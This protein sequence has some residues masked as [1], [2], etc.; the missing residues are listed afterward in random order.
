MFQKVFDIFWEERLF[1]FQVLTSHCI[2]VCPRWCLWWWWYNWSKVLFAHS[3][4][5]TYFLQLCCF[6]ISQIFFF[7]FCPFVS[8]FLISTIRYKSYQFIH[9]INPFFHTFALN[10]LL[11]KK[12]LPK[13]TLAS[14]FSD[15]PNNVDILGF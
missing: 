9:P 10:F 8:C 11:C 5:L 15:S 2:V 4:M 13:V 12:I 7:S 14:S 1:G 6:L 3:K